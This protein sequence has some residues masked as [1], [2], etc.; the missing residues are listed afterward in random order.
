MDFDRE[1]DRLVRDAAFA[2]LERLEAVHGDVLPAGALAGGFAFG[3]GRVPVVS[4]Q[5]IFKPRILRAPLSIRT[6]H[7]GPYAD[8]LGPSGLFRYMYRGDDPAHR[9]NA[10]LRFAMEQRLPLVYFIAVAPARYEALRPAYV[11]GE[12]RG[13]RCFWIAPGGGAPAYGLGD[14]PDIRAYAATQALQ[15]LH[16]GRFRERVLGAYRERCAFCSLR[17]RELLDAAHIIPD[18]EPG[19]VAEV[20]NGIALCRLHHATFDRHVVGVRP[21][22]HVITVRR[23]VM[24]EEDGPTLRYAIQGL[25]GQPMALPRRAGDRP[26]RGFLETRYRRFLAAPAP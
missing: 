8:E 26:E 9:D 15:R 18:A 7:D 22:D 1:H 3:S 25:D 4:P 21:H 13:D 16:Q 11:A 12:S 17:R 2:W 5:G 10:G 19:G 20:R 6:A 23:D 14:A 24:D